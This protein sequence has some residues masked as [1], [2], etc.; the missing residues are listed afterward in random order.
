MI[1][2]WP[3]GG[4]SSSSSASIDMAGQVTGRPRRARLVLTGGASARTRAELHP[5]GLRLAVAV[6]R[7]GDGVAG[8]VT[9]H[10]VDD[11][12]GRRHG[13]T[14]EPQDHVALLDAGLRRAR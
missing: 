1:C 6:H 5:V 12:F 14:V 2:T 3:R 7:D 11:V 13:C 10:R 8:R 9:T 4:I